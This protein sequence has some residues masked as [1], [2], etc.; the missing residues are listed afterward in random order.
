MFRCAAKIRPLPFSFGARKHGN[1]TAE[2]GEGAMKY[3]MKRLYP[4]SEIP[5]HPRHQ[6]ITA[7][8]QLAANCK[9]CYK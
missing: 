5:R 9:N 3:E 6:L 4:G 1:Q 8:S 2:C 7:L